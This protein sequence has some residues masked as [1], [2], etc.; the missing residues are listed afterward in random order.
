MAT[1]EG[2]EEKPRYL[3][4]MRLSAIYETLIFLVVVTLASFIFGD[5]DRFI[6]VSPHPFWIIVLTVTVQ[7]GTNEGIMASLLA[8]LFLYVW[9]V[10]EIKFNQSLF[11]YRL[12]LA[13]NPIM[14]IAASTFLGEIRMRQEAD[15]DRLKKEADEAIEQADT[16]AYAYE[17]LRDKKEGIEMR[18]AGQVRSLATAYNALKS[19]E[20]MN[21]AQIFLSMTEFIEQTIQPTKFS[22]FAFDDNGFEASVC[23]GWSDRENYSRRFGLDHPLTQA[24]LSRK[25]MVTAVNADDELILDGEGV[26]AC[27]IIDKESQKI[28]GMLKIEELPFEDM[29]VSN[30]EICST[31]CG[32]IG[33]TFANAK[34]FQFMVDN[35]VYSGEEV[36]CM[37]HALLEVLRGVYKKFCIEHNLPFFQVEFRSEGEVSDEEFKSKH[38]LLFNTLRRHFPSEVTIHTSEKPG[39]HLHLLAPAMKEAAVKQAVESAAKELEGMPEFKEHKIITAVQSLD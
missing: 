3:F 18:L 36:G 9:N 11:E 29:S 24:L 30:I 33:T 31:I 26:L 1:E 10:P 19:L 27:P 4:G 28:Y 32:L 6:N 23:E 22:V 5:G 34:K 13:A 16:I 15:R 14:W 17:T 37:S 35:T 12:S 21:P 38:A 39:L 8:T 20:S 2:Y 25:R 7:Y